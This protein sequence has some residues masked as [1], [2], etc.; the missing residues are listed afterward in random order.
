MYFNHV[1]NPGI[2]S[3]EFLGFS[4]IGFK[5]PKE[6][7]LWLEIIETKEC[8]HKNLGVLMIGFGTWAFILENLVCRP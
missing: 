4:I 8:A 1:P 5:T 2:E 3:P 7:F 6:K